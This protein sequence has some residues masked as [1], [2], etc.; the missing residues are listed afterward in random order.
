MLVKA[1]TKRGQNQQGHDD[2]RTARVVAEGI[3]L[4]EPAPSGVPLSARPCIQL[5][6]A[7]RLSGHHDRTR[8]PLVLVPTLLA[9]D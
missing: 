2:L 4:H 8:L 5:S 6:A 7:R 9:A 1:T 3:N